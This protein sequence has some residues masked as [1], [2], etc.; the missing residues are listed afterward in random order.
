MRNLVNF[1]LKNV[2]WL[3][4]FILTFFSLYLFIHNN[5]FQR[6]KYLSV[7]QEIAGR[8]YLVSN[9]VESYMNLKTINSDLMERV[10]VLE[11]ELRDSKQEVEVLSE[12]VYPLDVHPFEEAYPSAYTFLPAQVVNNQISRLSNNYITLNKGSLAGIKEDMGVL[13][14]SGIVGVV[15]S[16][17]PHFSKVISILNPKF[18]PNCKIKG[19]NFPGTLSWDGKDSRYSSLREL[20]QHAK[21]NIGDTV[22]TSGFSTVFPEGVPV[23]TVE[24]T[25]KKKGEDYN[26]LKVKLF[27]DFSTLSEVLI[28]VNALKDERLNIEKGESDE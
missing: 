10:A 25:F 26:S 6:S 3:L 17:S 8:V 11:K 7:F 24:D 28:V 1:I 2:H 16:V 18:Q 12:R 4:F 27:T 9:S 19:T 22:V 21:F 13:S 15:V 5:E 23:G 14:P 20:P